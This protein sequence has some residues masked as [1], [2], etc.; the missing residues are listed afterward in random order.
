MHFAYKLVFADSA[1]DFHYFLLLWKTASGFF[2]FMSA[3]VPNS[4]GSYWLV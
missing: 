3:Y 4:Q 1:K 2:F